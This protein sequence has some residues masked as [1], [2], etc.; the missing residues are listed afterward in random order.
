MKFLFKLK[1]SVNVK[2]LLE[3]LERGSYDLWLDAGDG[4]QGYETQLQLTSWSRP[5]RVIVL[6]RPASLKTKQESGGKL[7][8]ATKTAVQEELLFPE[9]IPSGQIPEYDWAVLVTNL[10]S[11]MAAVAQLYRDRGDCENIFDELKN[12][13][14]WGGFYYS[15]HQTLQHYGPNGGADIQLV[16]YLLPAGG[17]GQAYG[18]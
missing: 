11:S 15:G 18:G 1:Q 6:R 3:Q 10:D 12:R 9:V 2:K 5:R 14:G 17:T 13:R 16:E 8:T 7:L 4:W